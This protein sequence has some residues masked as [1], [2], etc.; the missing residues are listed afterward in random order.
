MNLD[1]NEVENRYFLVLVSALD[2]ESKILL[3]WTTQIPPNLD[4]HVLGGITQKIQK[5]R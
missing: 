5:F 4:F 3:I 2:I 1:M